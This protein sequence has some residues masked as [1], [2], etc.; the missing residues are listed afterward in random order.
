MLVFRVNIAMGAD[1]L[2][3]TKQNIISQAKEGTIVLPWYVD[4]IFQ[5]EKSEWI[6]VIPQE[7]ENINE[8]GELVE[9]ENEN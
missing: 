6:E 5:G 7:R 9:D 1:D 4:L 8:Y 3:R 2:R